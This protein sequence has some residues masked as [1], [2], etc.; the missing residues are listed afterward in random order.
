MLGD[1]F[2]SVAAKLCADVVGLPVGAGGL[3]DGFRARARGYLLGEP[4]T[5][6]PAIHV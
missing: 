1:Q 2:S 4:V 6:E 5:A 3:D